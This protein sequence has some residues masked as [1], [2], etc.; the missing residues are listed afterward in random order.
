MAGS[1]ADTGF[2]S[3]VAAAGDAVGAG[4]GAGAAGVDAGNEVE[5]AERAGA[6]SG[7]DCEAGGSWS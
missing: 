4:V 7:S 5:V 6:R 2:G 3:E 1:G